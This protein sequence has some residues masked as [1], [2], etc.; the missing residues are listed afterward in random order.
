MKWNKG[1]GEKIVF[2]RIRHECGVHA[3]AIEQ[4]RGSPGCVDR[5]FLL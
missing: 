4:D 5:C 1:E 3:Y 2:C